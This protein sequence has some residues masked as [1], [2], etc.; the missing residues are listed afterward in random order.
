MVPSA[1]P[2]AAVGHTEACT[3]GS[4]HPQTAPL[5]RKR[6][7]SPTTTAR[8]HMQVPLKQARPAALAK[9]VQVSLHCLLFWL[10]HGCLLVCPV[11]SCHHVDFCVI[12]CILTCCCC[13]FCPYSCCCCMCCDCAVLMLL[14]YSKCVC[15]GCV[16]LML[17]LLL[18]LLLSF[19]CA[20]CLSWFCWCCCGSFAVI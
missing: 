15:C 4:F 18:M 1:W 3:A 16:V 19:I 9:H 8:A 12:P 17:L 20:C 14:L 7:R 5:Q 2:T 10:H 6:S 13:H 11:L